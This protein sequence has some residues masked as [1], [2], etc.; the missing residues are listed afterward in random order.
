MA[1][2]GAIRK[3]RARRRQAA[4]RTGSRR[5]GA[6]TQAAATNAMIADVFDEI[7]DLLEL[8][9]ANPFRIRAYRNAARLLRGLGVE[10]AAMLADGKPLDELPGIGAD[11][12]AKIK[13]IAETGSTPLLGR[14]RRE[15]PHGLTELLKIPGLG[16]KRVKLIHDELAIDNPRQLHRATK[17]GRLRELPGLGEKTERRILEALER[18]AEAAPRTKLAVA[19]PQADA[20]VAY[21]AAVP[22]VSRAAAAGS[23]RRAR[24]TVGDLDLV[25]A[26]GPKSAV[27]D[28]FIAYREVAR[29]ESRG[30]T[31]ATVILRSGLQVDLRVVPPESYGAALY[32]FT[33]SKAHNIAVRRRAQERGLKVN[34]YGVFRGG[35]RIAGETEESVLKTVG[36]PYIPPELRENAGEIEA[37]EAGRLPALIELKDIRGDLHIHTRA[38]DGLNTVREMALAAKA[39]GY[40]YI[41]ITEHSQRLGMAHGLSAGRLRAQIAEIDR[42]NEEGLGIRILKGIEV[43][44]LEDGAL[45]L[46]DVTLGALDLVVG[47]IHSQFHLSRDRQTERIMRAMDH[48]CFSILAHPTGRLIPAREPYDVDMER[49]LR[50]AR[51]RGCFVELNAH[52]DRL[53]L[54]DTHCRMAK[55]EGVKVAINTDSHTTGDLANIRFG[56]AQARRGWLE[57]DDVLNTL[58]LDSLRRTLAK[59]IG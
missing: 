42:L 3:T 1:G 9:E 31:R 14:L 2:S 16:P 5:D 53:D 52:P 17:D 47:A 48:P 35:R 18:H 15:V 39:L 57:K 49:I 13:D 34:E 43:D 21:L 22:G 6:P 26:A 32:Y 55:A 44:I 40:A 33:G 58:E 30:P 4:S 54:T 38:T 27:M 24:E 51:A 25:V 56:V 8:E 19:A 41:A 11:L 37:A 23:L 20:L 50:K 7:A 59:T 46:D 10:V 45:D 29:V 12:A 36:L 28:R